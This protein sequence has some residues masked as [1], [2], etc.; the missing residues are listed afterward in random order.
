[1][2][3]AS[4]LPRD[5]R[6]VIRRRHPWRDTIEGII[7]A[8]IL[9]LIIR[10][11][12]FEVFKIPTGSMAPTL[13]G[14]HRDLHC[15]NCGLRF[16][17]DG[18]SQLQDYIASGY[19][20]FE[21]P[22]CA[23]TFL[24]AKVLDACCDCFPPAI[25]LPV[26]PHLLFWEGGNRVIV[27]KFLY[28]FNPPKRWD[29]IVFKYPKVDLRCLHCGYTAT[30]VPQAEA[31]ARCPKCGWRTL[32]T[33]QKAYIKRLIG[34]PGEE[35]II[36]HGDIYIDGKLARKPPE[37]QEAVW[38]LV[39]DSAYPPLDP[40]RRDTPRWR[41]EAGQFTDEKGRLELLPGPDG[42][43]RVRYGPDIED[44]TSYN[45]R[46]PG[47]V[48]ALVGDLR[49]DVRVQLDKP[50]LLR[51][52]IMEDE[53]VHTACVAFGEAGSKTRLEVDGRSEGE[54]DFR[55]DPAREHRVAFSNVDDR[56][57]LKVDGQA[58]LTADYT[59]SVADRACSSGAEL[60]VDGATA[61]FARVRLDRDLYYVRPGG[62]PTF[63][64][65]ETAVTP[66]DSYFAMGDNTRNSFDSRYWGGVP[67]GNLIGHAMVVWWPLNDLRPVH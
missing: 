41:G 38:R 48:R 29:V 5:E 32:W 56:L 37:V 19:L 51:L 10:H 3:T 59:P 22:N 7:S 62:G 42:A 64:R 54:S 40:Q 9:V 49:W 63:M 35:V 18:G 21:C 11:F 67:V 2:A 25:R 6:R 15:P 14:Q 4:L 12:T 65:D 61:R 26:R 57:E 1:M 39:Y 27:N 34:L 43:A 46:R 52:S 8:V 33:S 50:G 36:R 66:A 28:A 60:G 16:P 24:P 23:Y 44:F 30:D 31:P 53:T 55:A 20:N 47:D 17:V 58:I 45:G 13:L